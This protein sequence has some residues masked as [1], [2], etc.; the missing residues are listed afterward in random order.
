[1]DVHDAAF[2]RAQKFALQHAHETGEH[3]QIHFGC[4]QRDDKCTLGLLVQLG[5]EFSRRDELRR[6]F[7][8]ARVR[9]NSRAL[10]I[11]QHDGDFR[12]NFS[13][14]DSIGNRGKV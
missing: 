2:K 13:R 11:A 1:M 10:D 3:D 14:S 6:N 7:P 4:L 12:R 5:A 8:F 9:Q